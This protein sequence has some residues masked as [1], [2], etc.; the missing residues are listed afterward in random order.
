MH[1][2]ACMK[3]WV[4]LGLIVEMVVLLTVIALGAQAAGYPCCIPARVR[5]EPDSTPPC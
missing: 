4:L 1:T 5:V 3:I 2:S